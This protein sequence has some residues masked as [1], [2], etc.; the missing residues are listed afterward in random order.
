[1]SRRHEHLSQTAR[2]DNPSQSGNSVWTGREG[3]PPGP[4]ASVADPSSGN[5]PELRGKM[6]PFNSGIVPMTAG[7]L[8]V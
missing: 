5:H 6:F 7:H 8:P 2:E 3:V 1:M 4:D